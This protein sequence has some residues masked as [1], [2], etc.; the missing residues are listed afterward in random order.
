MTRI[1]VVED[2]A[3]YAAILEYLLK[4]EGYDVEVAPTGRGAVEAAG[5]RAFDA[6][7]VDHWMPDMDGIHTIATLREIGH[8]FGVILLTALV[9]SEIEDLAD[10]LDI[11]KIVDK[12][13]V[14]EDRFLEVVQN[15]VEF[16]QMMESGNGRPTAGTSR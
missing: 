9:P 11:W 7:I 3:A 10:G 13:K 2:N 4:A 14:E 8:R 12:T 1:L 5:S 16:T 6:V 15:A